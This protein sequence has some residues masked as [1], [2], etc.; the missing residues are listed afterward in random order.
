VTEFSVIQRPP[1]AAAFAINMPVWRTCVRQ[2]ALVDDRSVIPPDAPVWHDEAAYQHLLEVVCG[3]HSPIVGETEVMHQF[4]VFAEGLEEGAARWRA[5]CGQVLSDAR[6][7]RS[8]HLIGLGSR[9]YGS[10]V[11]RHVGPLS[12]V[13]IIGTGMLARKIVPFLAHPNRIVDLWGRRPDCSIAAAGLAYRPCTSAP[14]VVE[15]PAAI[16]VAAPATSAAIVQLASGYRALSLLIDLRAE[17]VEDPVPPVARVVTL[18][19]VFADFEAVAKENAHRVR[20]AKAAIGSC[21]RDFTT[22]ARLNPSGWHDLC[23]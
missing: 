16:V 5:L 3:L 13:A 15:G 1:Q 14:I 9:S 12:R 18:A 4:K 8:T 19:D 10:A 11:R 2:V 20:A 22:R 6:A 17:G 7:I 21:A 23:A